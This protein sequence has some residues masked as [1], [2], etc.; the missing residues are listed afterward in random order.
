MVKSKFSNQGITLIGVLIAISILSL[1]IVGLGRSLVARKDVVG[2]GR[3]KLIAASIAREGLELARALRDDNWLSQNDWTT[4]LCD[5]ASFTIDAATV[6][7]KNDLGSSDDA[8]LFIADDGGEW[9]HDQN[10]GPSSGYNRLI[11]IDC[12][13]KDNDPAFIT[14]T[15]KVTWTSRGHDNNVEIKEKLFNWITEKP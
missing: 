1:T 6:R 3:E 7:N 2:A 15:S 13:E 12:A 11:N 8:E 5:N 14:V 9:L 4:Q 10:A